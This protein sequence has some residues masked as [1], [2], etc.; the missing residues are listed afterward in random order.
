MLVGM[1][2][3]NPKSGYSH[4]YLLPHSLIMGLGGWA[5]TEQCFAWMLANVPAGSK[6][7]EFGSGMGT[8]ELC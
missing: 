7:L 8:G 6:V 1:P 3:T 4:R 2:L 5:I